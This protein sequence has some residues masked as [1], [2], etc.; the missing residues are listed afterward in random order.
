MCNTTSNCTV[1]TQFAEKLQA[2]VLTWAF[3]FCSIEKILY[4]LDQK[5][6]VG[7]RTT[8]EGEGVDEE[9]WAGDIW[10]R[11]RGTIGEGKN[12]WEKKE[13]YGKEACQGREEK[14]LREFS[15]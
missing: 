10:K 15:C 9:G 4:K 14:R 7:K 13:I 2:L 8:I 6:E 5:E 11:D 1:L 3:V 12:R